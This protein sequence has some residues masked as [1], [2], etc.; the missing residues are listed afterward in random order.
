MQS[1]AEFKIRNHNSKL[2]PYHSLCP[3]FSIQIIAYSASYLVDSCDDTVSEGIE[4]SEDVEDTAP[5]RWIGLC[6]LL[7]GA[8]H[9]PLTKSRPH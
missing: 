7:A 8:P 6:R 9:G 4:A 3:W 5:A 2:N 1:N